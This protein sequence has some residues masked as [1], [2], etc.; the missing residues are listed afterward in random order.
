MNFAKRLKIPDE[1]FTQK[2]F[3]NSKFN[4][5]ANSNQPNRRNYNKI[6]MKHL[7]SFSFF[8]LSFELKIYTRI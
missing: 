1:Y 5:I 2:M 4:F 8:Y 3:K 7:L 6:S